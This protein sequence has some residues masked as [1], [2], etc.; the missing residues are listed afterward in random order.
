MLTALGLV[1]LITITL[2]IWVCA[3]KIAEQCSASGKRRRLIAA[4]AVG[5]TLFC[6]GIGGMGLYHRTVDELFGIS[7]ISTF[8]GLIVTVAVS[9]TFLPGAAPPKPKMLRKEQSTRVLVL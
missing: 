4:L 7:K 8:L 2:V 5:L 1:I 6:L 9:T 3:S